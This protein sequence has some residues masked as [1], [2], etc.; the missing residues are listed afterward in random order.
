MPKTGSFETHTCRYEDWFEKNRDVYH[1]ELEAVRELIPFTGAEG[2]EVGVGSGRFA[3]PLG[4]KS[5][6]EPS[7]KMATIAEERGIRVYRD[8]A[9]SLPFSDGDFDFVLMVTVICFV[10][11]ILKSFRE[12]FRVLKP[13]GCI[14]VEQKV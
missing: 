7:E 13:G 9:E 6:V 2:L 10:D 12:A 1:A 11:D 5:G 4:I 14:I 8:V 3:V